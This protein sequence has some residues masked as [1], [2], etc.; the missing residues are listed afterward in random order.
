VKK[1]PR[2]FCDN[3]G[4]EVGADVKTC[5]YCGRYF[6]S[7]RCPACDYSGPDK[8][9]QNGCPMCGY[10]SAPP[11]QKAKSYKPRE[12][13]PRH[14]AEPL[15]TWAFILSILALFG[16]IWLLSWLIFR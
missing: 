2:F 13:K 10:S 1:K 4:Y 9:F 8:M 6:A 16:I 3:C 7:I 5:P 14:K 11:P 12:K 15:P